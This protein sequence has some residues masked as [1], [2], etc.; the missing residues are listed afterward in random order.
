MSSNSF[1]PPAKNPP[2]PPPQKKKN[3]PQH[4]HQAVEVRNP[5]TEVLA[6]L[7]H[8]SNVV[9]AFQQFRCAWP[10]TSPGRKKRKLRYKFSST[11]K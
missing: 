7:G 5:P 1:G 6:Q 11:G 4:R 9:H 2:P 10:I 3:P 8:S